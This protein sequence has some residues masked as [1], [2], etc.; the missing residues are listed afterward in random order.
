MVAMVRHGQCLGLGW[1]LGVGGLVVMHMMP[2]VMCRR[3]LLML[4]IR[5]CRTPESLEGQSQQQEDGDKAAHGAIIGSAHAS[6]E[7]RLQHLQYKVQIF[8]ALFQLGLMHDVIDE[9][10]F[11]DRRHQAVHSTPNGRDLL[12]HGCA[13]TFLSELLFQGCG[14]ALDAPDTGQQLRFVSDGVHVNSMAGGM[15]LQG[16]GSTNILGGSIMLPMSV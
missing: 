15:V 10:P 16:K 1:G 6:L 8:L 4:A 13:V 9:M 14:L 12:Q 3:P 7:I 5:L 2:D 11:D